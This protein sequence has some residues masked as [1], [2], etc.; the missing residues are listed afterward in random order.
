MVLGEQALPVRSAAPAPEVD[1]DLVLL[2]GDVA[3]GQGRRG[4]RHVDDHVDA[5]LVVPLP[6]DVRC[7]VGLVLVVGRDDLDVD[8]LGGGSKSSTAIWAATTEP[9]PARSA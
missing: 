8:A 9:S 7:D 2:P 4:G 6:G 5:V 3:D 1:E